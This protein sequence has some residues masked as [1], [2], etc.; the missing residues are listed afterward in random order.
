MPRGRGK[1]RKQGNRVPEAQSP[2]KSEP[3]SGF[4]R[5]LEAERIIGVATDVEQ[6]IRFLIKWKNT[7]Q[8]ELVLAKIA[9]EK[10]PQMVIKFYEERLTW[11]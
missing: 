6:N 7:D 10:I 2:A 9:N 11:V 8:A 1:S 3:K 4:D 5:A